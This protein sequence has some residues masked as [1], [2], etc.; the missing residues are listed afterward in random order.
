MKLQF[1][2]IAIVMASILSFTQL[3]ASSRNTESQFVVPEELR[4]DLT[5]C[6]M[7]FLFKF[8]PVQFTLR[9]EETSAARSQL[10]AAMSGELVAVNRAQLLLTMY[11][12]TCVEKTVQIR[13]KCHRF[14]EQML[15]NVKGI[16]GEVL[17][18]IRMLT[19]ASVQHVK[20]VKGDPRFRFSFKGTEHDVDLAMRVL[21]KWI[22]YCQQNAK[23]L[24][25][26]YCT[27]G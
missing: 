7:N 4:A 1:G 27:T 17:L 8:A 11:A 2:R 20:N 22:L 15:S 18:Y 12:K 5:D 10:R 3:Q 25:S 16:C 24:S 21:D 13:D 9:Y 6:V 14:S 19:G 23:R 26:R